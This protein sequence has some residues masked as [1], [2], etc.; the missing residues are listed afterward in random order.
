MMF[1]SGTQFVNICFLLKLL[2]YRIKILICQSYKK[3]EE[4]DVA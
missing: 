4:E 1:V 2:R 3:V